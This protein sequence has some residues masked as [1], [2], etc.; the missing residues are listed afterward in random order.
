[1]VEALAACGAAAMGVVTLVWPTWWESLVGSSPDGGSGSTERWL[2][3][4]WAGAALALALLSRRDVLAVRAP[5][6][7]SS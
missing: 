5:R 6:R 3:I 2:A 1:M 4:G 7:V